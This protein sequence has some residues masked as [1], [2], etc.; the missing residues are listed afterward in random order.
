MS[1]SGPL[2]HSSRACLKEGSRG[3]EES[4]SS[5]LPSL[6]PN[7]LLQEEDSPKHFGVLSRGELLRQLGL[8][9]AEVLS[10][11]GVLLQERLESW[12]TTL[13]HDGEEIRILCKRC[14]ASEKAEGDVDE[15]KGT[16]R[17][18]LGA[19]LRRSL[20]DAYAGVGRGVGSA[21]ADLILWH[22][23]A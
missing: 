8:L 7:P 3:T 16:T 9:L 14:G 12:R 20:D 18:C 19:E 1:D 11:L 4:V 21:Q 22:K 6:T 10:E 17:R 15:G 13:M 5:L 23:A 2:S